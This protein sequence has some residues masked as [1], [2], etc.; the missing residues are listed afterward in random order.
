MHCFC[1]SILCVHSARQ[2]CKRRDCLLAHAH[3]DVR[4]E[5]HLV[6]RQLARS[7]VLGNNRIRRV[8]NPVRSL[9]WVRPTNR[10][11][12]VLLRV[13]LRTRLRHAL[14]MLISWGLE[15]L[16]VVSASSI[17]HSFRSGRFPA[18]YA[19][20]PLRMVESGNRASITEA[21]VVIPGFLPFRLLAVIPPG[22]TTLH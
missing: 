3:T 11:D 7:T 1:R 16:P 18:K 2:H 8:D 10:G 6:L 21:V 15:L 22:V 13:S 9:A 14:L 12:R 19:W 5:K 4:L 20:S 17:P